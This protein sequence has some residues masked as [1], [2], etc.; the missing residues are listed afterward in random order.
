MSLLDQELVDILKSRAA[1]KPAEPA[2]AELPIQNHVTPPQ[3]AVPVVEPKVAEPTPASAVAAAEPVVDLDAP[4]EN[5][6]IDAPVAPVPEPVVQLDVQTLAKELGFES[7]KTKEELAKA[8]AEVKIKAEAA[9]KNIEVLPEDLTKAVEI[10]RQGGNYLE[11]LKVSSVDWS[12]QDPIS[13]FE[14]WVFDRLAKQNKTV[15][16]IDAYLDKVDD[17]DK[18]LRG[19]ELQMQYTNYQNQQR[20]AIEAQTRQ[21]RQQFE[22]ATQAALNSISDVYG[23]KLSQSHKETLFRDFTSSQIGRA[24]LAQ[25]NGDFKQALT[26]LFNV[27][28]G[29]KIDQFRKQQIKNST[30]RELLNEITNPKI[31]VTGA[32]AQPSIDKIDPIK[33]YLSE[34]QTKTGL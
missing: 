21:E 31:T 16:E 2:P 19:R 11:Y 18:D 4:V 17:V 15:E 30:K 27:K 10:A 1:A 22:N 34:L 3:P 6:E 14:N 7:A 9:S 33:T 5:W 13:L 24:L 32:L 26:G 28:Y 20:A 29:A 8:I 12:K 25:S 23:F